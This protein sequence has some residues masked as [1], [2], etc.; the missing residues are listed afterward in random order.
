MIYNV[1][2]D[3][4]KKRNTAGLKAPADIAT[5]SEKNGY[6][7]FDIPVYN[8]GNSKI[9]DKLVLAWIMASYLGRLFFVLKPGDQVI[10]QH[11][12]YG[13][14]PLIKGIPIIRRFRRAEFIVLIHDLPSLRT[15]VRGWTE[16][17]AK[18]SR[19]ADSEFLR[20]FDYVISHNTHMSEYLEQIGIPVDK[21]RN[22][23]IFDYINNSKRKQPTKC[24]VPTITIAGYLGKAKCNYIYDMIG[25]P[26]QLHVNLYGL[27]FDEESKKDN[28]TYFGSFN[29]EEL[30][31]HLEGDFGLVWDGESSHTC[32]GIMGEYLRYNNP[33]K[34]SLYLSSAMP[35][36]VWKEAAIA[37]F[38]R[39][40][41]VGIVVDSLN[42]IPTAIQAL[43][44]EEYQEICENVNKISDKLRSGYYFTKAVKACTK[45][46]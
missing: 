27:E 46:R 39:D 5:I 28:M 17:R 30:V 43:S 23:E 37:D 38:V 10:M 40:H 6:K 3:V 44:V 21:I 4:Y 36:I 25:D 11:P 8:T 33:H 31:D 26:N 20:T 42:E 34:T 24:K 13:I 2:V 18:W 7:R 12:N 16:E 22:L 32:T 1:F 15:D 9:K 29:P 14:K 45:R 19:L 35:V 41:K